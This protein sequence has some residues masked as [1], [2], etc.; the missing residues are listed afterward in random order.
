MKFQDVTD[1]GCSAC[2]N[3]TKGTS[4]VSQ[5]NSSTEGVHW[6]LAVHPTTH[7][8]ILS[9]EGTTSER[10]MTY[11]KDI[12]ITRTPWPPGVDDSSVHNGFLESMIAGAP[13]AMVA[14]EKQ[15]AKTPNYR[16]AITGHSLGAAQAVLFVTYLAV[17]RRQWLVNTTVYTYGQPRVGNAAFAA[18]YQS[19]GVPT[20]RVVNQHD[21]VPRMPTR[22]WGFA[23][24]GN[25]VWI[26]PDDSA[27]V[28][29]PSMGVEENPQC[30]VS[31]SWHE[32]NVAD[33]RQYFDART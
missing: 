10:V 3:E 4:F 12:Q 11:F 20:T 6:Y 33:H 8:I 1:W 9:F 14:L 26:R 23:H 19:L 5:F 30:S 32:L 31:L 17:R 25:E 16:L 13:G 24:H 2:I 7:T 18:Y 22:A 28:I 15:W 21:V 27:V 29:C